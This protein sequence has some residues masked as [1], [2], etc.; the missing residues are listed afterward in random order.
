MRMQGSEFSPIAYGFQPRCPQYSAPRGQ[1]STSIHN[2]RQQ[3]MHKWPSKRAP[4]RMQTMLHVRRGIHIISH[5][6]QHD[7]IRITQA[8]VRDHHVRHKPQCVC[9]TARYGAM[10]PTCGR[11]FYR[12]T[13]IAHAHL[14]H[15]N[16]C[17]LPS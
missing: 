3:A 15:V 9:R 13:A 1:C 11:S 2:P 7:R 12:P 8:Q 6:E 10:K 14:P 16:A 5:R 4:P 17:M